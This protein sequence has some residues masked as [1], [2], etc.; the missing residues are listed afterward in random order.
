MM[1]HTADVVGAAL[2]MYRTAE[3]GGA[4]DLVDLGLRSLRQ[5]VGGVAP[6]NMVVLGAATNVGKSSILLEMAH[7]TKD[8]GL[9][10]SKED[11]ADI[12]GV[13]LLARHAGVRDVS[14]RTN[15]LTP[16]ERERLLAVHERAM[17]GEIKD[18]PVVLPE[19]CSTLEKVDLR[20]E[21]AA[22]IGAKWAALDFLQRFRGLSDNRRTE[23]GIVMDRFQTK[24]RELGMVAVLV[25]QLGRLGPFAKPRLS[26][27]KESGD[28]EN[29]A[30]LIL[31]AHRDQSCPS[32]VLVEVAKSSFG[33]GGSQFSMKYD[34]CGVL[35]E[36]GL[37]DATEFVSEVEL[38]W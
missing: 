5:T 30:K 33:G 23:I 31:L 21:E 38:T 3:P 25:S 1:R 19:H 17:S 11:G 2:S 34:D 32:R 36:E 10:L 26:D 16:E 6:G 29:E 20:L 28:I 7:N 13:R 15:S 9:I 8:T 4:P 22:A 37:I 14:I 12:V 35:H 24:C 27:L 18:V